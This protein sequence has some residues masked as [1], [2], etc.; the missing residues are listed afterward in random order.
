M[1]KILILA[2]NPTDTNRVRLDEEVR[3]IENAYRQANK[4]EKIDIISKWAV[5]VD[6]L[7]RELL[8]YNP[9]IVHFCGHGR[10]DDGLV[11]LNE[12]GQIQLV[13]SK[14][15]AGLFQLFK[16]HVDCV[17]MNA[18]YSERQA[19][20][21]YQHINCVIGMNKNITDKAAIKFATGFYDA[22]CNGRKYEDSFYF[23][24]NAIN[25]ENIPEWQTPQIFIRDSSKSLLD[26]DSNTPEILKNAFGN[27][28]HTQIKAY[29]FSK[30]K[31]IIKKYQITIDNIYKTYE[32]YFAR[33][34]QNNDKSLW[35]GQEKIKKSYDINQLL[36][37]ICEQ[38]KEHSE[39]NREEFLDMLKN[40]GREQQQPSNNKS[41]E[42]NHK[43]KSLQS[44]HSYL[45]I[46]LRP[47][48][49]N[50]VFFKAW[51]I[52]DDTI[53]SWERFKSLTVDEQQTEI[54]FVSEKLP[55]LLSNLLG[56]CFEKYLQGQPTELT[57]EIFLPR[58][59]LHDQVEKWKYL[60]EEE[61]YRIP[62]GKEYR[63]VVRSYDRL[64]TLHKKQGSQWKKNWENVRSSWQNI[65]CIHK[66][67]TVSQACFD[68]N[69]LRE[70]LTEKILLKV[71]C[72]LSNLERNNVLRAIH[73]A[74]TPIVLW[75]RCE[76]NSLH[77]PFDFDALL[78]KPLYE[79]SARVKEQRLAADNDKHLGNH[80]VL[81]WDDPNR[82]PPNPALKF[83]VS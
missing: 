26:L 18:C 62:I 82:V 27:K 28:A 76:V 46:Q 43:T 36:D 3:S 55:L 42:T 59:R 9:N 63:V 39:E 49:N 67:T 33:F 64:K 56:Q 68:D 15:L 66:M 61:G 47:G 31:D 21:I 58:D 74:A 20:A 5:R 22:L 17:V 29:M 75:S 7:R 23:G 1:K 57:I 54:P 53:Q 77:N 16:D 65:P 12:S 83:S 48:A 72:T 51:F 80:L 14:S 10:G 24:R 69:E 2:A 38:L 41:F 30:I 50:K 8:Y 78:D 70:R 52:P 37:E 25:L 6:D 71:C 34:N 19:R 81:L 79:L 44:L 73:S 32:D 45:L 13:D 35:K 40:T 60:D 4:R 11:L